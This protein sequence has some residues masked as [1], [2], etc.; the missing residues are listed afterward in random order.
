MS[1][2]RH[3]GAA[4]YADEVVR[5]HASQGWRHQFVFQD[6]LLGNC[7]VCGKAKM[8]W[9]GVHHDGTLDNDYRK[10]K[11]E[12]E[13][14]WLLRKEFDRAPQTDVFDPKGVDCVWGSAHIK[15]YN[16]RLVRVW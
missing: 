6:L 5:L 16:K 10:I 2:M 7:C 3:C 8:F 13:P 12:L 1:R 4:F 14:D 15:P 9:Q 11:Q